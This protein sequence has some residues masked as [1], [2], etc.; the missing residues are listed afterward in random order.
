[1]FSRLTPRRLFAMIFQVKE[2]KNSMT[3]EFYD[4]GAVRATKEKLSRRTLQA[5]AYELHLEN[6]D[7]PTGQIARPVAC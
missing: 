3:K 7:P 6:T 4:L 2:P 1:M 5:S